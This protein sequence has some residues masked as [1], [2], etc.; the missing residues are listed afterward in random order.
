[1][2][3]IRKDRIRALEDERQ[4]PAGY[5]AEY[6]ALAGEE[7]ETFFR[8]SRQAFDALLRKYAPQR[9]AA[10]RAVVVAPKVVADRRPRW[11]WWV[12][13]IAMLRSKRDGGLGDTI[14][15]LL[16]VPGL[17][18]ERAMAWLG[19][20]CGCGGHQATLNRRYRY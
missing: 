11:P 16:W 15:R 5:Y 17:T 18:F 3:R 1:M 8:L 12:R 13:G 20:D 7:D 2:I 6:Q 10:R 4:R 19:I 9:L 14:K